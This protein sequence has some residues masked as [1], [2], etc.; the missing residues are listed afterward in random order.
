M[1]SDSF[2]NI[3][4]SA[5]L[6]AIVTFASFFAVWKTLDTISDFIDFIGRVLGFE[7]LYLKKSKEETYSQKLSRVSKILLQSSLEVDKL[8]S[9]LVQVATDR[10]KAVRTLEVELKELENRE[11]K[12][13]EQI[14]TLENIPIPVAEHFAKL[15]SMGEKKSAKRD[16]LLFTAGIVASAIVSI[17]LKILGLA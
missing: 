7:P 3:V 5:L 6:V 15:N 16:Y 4:V 9:E 2:T 1:F 14:K 17:I 13:Q 10:E 8:L 11:R 12:L